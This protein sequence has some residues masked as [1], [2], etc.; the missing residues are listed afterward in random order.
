MTSSIFLVKIVSRGSR[1]G[2]KRDLSKLFGVLS[3]S[4]YA[5]RILMCWLYF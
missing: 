3:L 4:W 1:G 2:G 5:V